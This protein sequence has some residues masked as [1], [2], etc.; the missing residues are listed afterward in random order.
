MSLFMTSSD[1]SYSV[2][3]TSFSLL[4]HHRMH[5]GVEKVALHLNLTVSPTSYIAFVSGV[6]S[7]T[8]IVEARTL[9]IS[10]NRLKRKF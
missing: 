5:D 10:M 2:N 4:I 8:L 9:K 1:I 7:V 6:S 3:T